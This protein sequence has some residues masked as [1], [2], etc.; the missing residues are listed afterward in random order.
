MQKYLDEVWLLI[1]QAIALDVAPM[2]FNMN[3]S[4]ELLDRTFI[5]GCSMVKLERTE[6]QFLWGLCVLVLF[7]AHH[8][9]NNS[10]VKINLDYSQDKKFGEFIVHGLDDPK[11][12]DL[13]LP[14]LFSLTTEVFFTK[15]FLSVDIC[16]ELLQVSFLGCKTC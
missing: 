13:V 9:V 16:V 10:A 5:S 8:S 6:F 2:E 11:P 4:E 3:E 1:L 7:H 15:N 12:C 14:V